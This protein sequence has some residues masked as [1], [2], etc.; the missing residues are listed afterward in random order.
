VRFLLVRQG[1]SRRPSLVAA[2][3]R[4]LA[5]RLQDGFGVLTHQF[6]APLAGF[7]IPRLRVFAAPFA[8]VQPAALGSL[9][10]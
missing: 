7:G 9:L 6:R 10:V 8:L 4:P 5:F 2:A 1:R 3:L